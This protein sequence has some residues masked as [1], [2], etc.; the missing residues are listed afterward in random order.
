MLQKSHYDI[1]EFCWHLAMHFI[2]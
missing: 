1:A 2:P